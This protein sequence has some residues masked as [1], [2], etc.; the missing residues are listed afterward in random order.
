MLNSLAMALR[1]PSRL[2]L[3]KTSADAAGQAID[4]PTQAKYS[5][6]F[7]KFIQPLLDLMMADNTVELDETALQFCVMMGSLA[8]N[9]D[10]LLQTSAR[11][12]QLLQELENDE[13]PS[14]RDIF[15]ALV[16]RRRT[17]FAHLT[18]YLTAE[19]SVSEQGEMVIRAYAGGS[20]R[21]FENTSF[22]P[23]EE[24]ARA[25]KNNANQTCPC[26]SGKKYKKCCSHA[27]RPSQ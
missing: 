25:T 9:Y 4:S 10:E 18:F 17:D 19:R 12:R 23:R 14:V 1:N 26:G 16:A 2:R 7:T 21:D 5:E 11:G 8:W 20:H 22:R 24:P 15:K 27:D 3:T 6:L 13:D